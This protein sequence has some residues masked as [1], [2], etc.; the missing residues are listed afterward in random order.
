M[1]KLVGQSGNMPSA[2]GRPYSG[3]VTSTSLLRLLDLVCQDLGAE[4]SRIEVGGKDPDDVRLVWCRLPAGTRL[5]V[6]F[7]QPPPERD[8]IAQRLAAWTESF[9]GLLSWPGSE[10][11]KS[12]AVGIAARLDQEL[13]RL[14]SRA[15]ARGAAVIDR[16][17]SVV[18]GFV[19]LPPPEGQGE[20]VLDQA[21]ARLRQ[22]KSRRRR[23][24]LSESG[25]GYVARGFGGTYTLVLS[26]DGPFSEL[27]AEA[28]LGR[29]L[30]RVERL[31]LGLPT[32]DPPRG[33]RKHQLALV[34]PG[35]RG[36]R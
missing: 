35:G 34:P 31:V 15:G 27:Q 30:G 23:R 22:D 4:D 24:V 12:A 7:A 8:R 21:I 25:L 18:W 19:E 28:A 14:A 1:G 5:V 33:G 10:R 3:W 32:R 17:S 13:G 6:V 26:Y 36:H 2:L 20:P 29:A 16:Q 9:E 11:P